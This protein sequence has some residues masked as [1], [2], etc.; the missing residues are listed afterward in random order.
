MGYL[1]KEGVLFAKKDF[2]LPKHPEMP[3]L[4]VIKL[5]QSFTS[6]GYCKEAF[7]WRHHYW[8][9]TDEG[10]TY[11]REFLNLPEDA[12]PATLKKATRAPSAPSRPPPGDERGDRRPGGFGSRD[13]DGRDSYRTG[14][15]DD[16]KGGVGMG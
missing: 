12:V 1:F 7:A 9:L 13:R 8:F 11:L 15:R 3:D 5:M 10:L 4:H 14:Q 2:S 6:R 16:D